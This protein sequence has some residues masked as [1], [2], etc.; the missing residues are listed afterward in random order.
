MNEDPWVTAE[1]LSLRPGVKGAVYRWRERNG[2]PAQKI[3]RVWKFQLS[4][5]D[6]WVR[7]GRPAKRMSEAALGRLREDQ[8]GEYPLSPDRPV[9]ERTSAQNH[10]ERAGTGPIVAEAVASLSALTQSAANEE[11]AA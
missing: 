9:D 11:T 1:Q 6:E 5:V 8:R 2:L 4:E 3:G 10:Q 7:A